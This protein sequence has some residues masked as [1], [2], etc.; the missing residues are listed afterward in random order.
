MGKEM[1]TFDDIKIEKHKFLRYKSPIFLED[2]DINNV[3]VSNKISFGDKTYK[4]FIVYLYD[5]YK[6][7]LLHIT[8]KYVKR[9]R[10]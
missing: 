10:M 1:I 8:S 6:M 9:A 2:V 4:Y 3:L 7:K 5:D